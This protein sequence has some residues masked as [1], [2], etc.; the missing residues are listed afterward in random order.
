LIWLLVIGVPTVGLLWF[1]LANVKFG[2]RLTD[3]KM[4]WYYGR[5]DWIV[6]ISDID[7]VEISES[8]DSCDVDVILT[9]GESFR[10]DNH[11]FPGVEKLKSV[12]AQSDITVTGR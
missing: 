11:C 8:S 2:M 12:L 9:T 3:T 6:A 7:R 1:I 5:H 10:V 4:H